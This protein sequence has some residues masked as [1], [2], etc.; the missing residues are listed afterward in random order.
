M[1]DFDRAL[2][3]TFVVELDDVSWSDGRQCFIA[4]MPFTAVLHESGDHDLM[5]YVFQHRGWKLREIS[6]EP[7][8]QGGRCVDLFLEQLG[9]RQ[10]FP[11]RRAW[12]PGRQDES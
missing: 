9:A 3:G 8:Y 12:A 6:A 7:I 10:V 4:A 1:N 5:S 2:F 11:L